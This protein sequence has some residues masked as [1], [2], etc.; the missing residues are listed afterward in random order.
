MKKNK[1][2]IFLSIF[3]LILIFG[4][5]ATCNF[6][7]LEVKP[8][9]NEAANQENQE[10]TEQGSSSQQAQQGN[11]SA[12][13]QHDQ[14]VGDD[15]QGGQQQQNGDEAI[16][17]SDQQGQQ[18]AGN[19]DVDDTFP[20]ADEIESISVTTQIYI[21]NQESGHLIDGDPKF[22]AMEGIFAG[23]KGDKL[24]QGFI[25]LDISELMEK[26][27]KEATFQF[28]AEPIGNPGIFEQVHFAS[29]FWGDRP[30]GPADFTAT[31]DIFAS[32]PSAVSGEQTF[33]NQML[34]N[35]LQE[36]INGGINKFQLKVFVSG[37]PNGDA[38]EDGIYFDGQSIRIIA[39]YDLLESN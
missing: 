34:F 21:L 39:V 24:C 5:A 12:S 3:T 26:K 19:E 15:Q 36:T 6:C 1:L 14:Q 37:N 2:F 25:T 18:Q 9:D 32:Y 28:R 10:S 38:I 8:S 16:D 7:G 35:K 29:Y 30:P 31:S 20:M 4:I 17:N 33:T 22:Y 11:D 23:E 27:L 13:E